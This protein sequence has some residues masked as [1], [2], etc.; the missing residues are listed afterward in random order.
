[1]RVVRCLRLELQ[2][3]PTFCDRVVSTDLHMG[4]RSQHS[5]C[6]ISLLGSAGSSAWARPAALT[7][8]CAAGQNAIGGQGENEGRRLRPSPVVQKT[9]AVRGPLVLC[10]DWRLMEGP[11]GQGKAV[12]LGT[13]SGSTTPHAHLGE[14]GVLAPP[15]APHSPGLGGAGSPGRGLS[16]LCSCTWIWD[17]CVASESE[18]REPLGTA[19]VQFGECRCLRGTNPFLEI[20]TQKELLKRKVAHSRVGP[21]LAQGRA[22]SSCTSGAVAP[23]CAGGAEGWGPPACG[24][25]SALSHC[26]HH[27]S[28]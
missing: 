22:C 24:C 21:C 17:V 16:A 6:K 3:V 8:P 15:V 5:R 19:L 12:I 28:C 23:S 25:V 10:E 14:G 2:F 1:M 13:G 11:R 20:C 26:R 9:R 4:L 7:G 27:G 18:G